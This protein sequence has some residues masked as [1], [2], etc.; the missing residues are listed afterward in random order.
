MVL[1]RDGHATAF[2]GATGGRGIKVIPTVRGH[3]HSARVPSVNETARMEVVSAMK[4]VR[5]GD[6]CYVE[7]TEFTATT[8]K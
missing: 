1:A 5:R 2:D 8:W 4:G 6:M 3:E 7:L